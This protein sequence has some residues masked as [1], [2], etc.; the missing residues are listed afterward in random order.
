MKSG[1]ITWTLRNQLINPDIPNE[2]NLGVEIRFRISGSIANPKFLN[3]N[4]DFP[5]ERNPRYMFLDVLFAVRLRNPKRV[6]KTVLENSGLA[7]ARIIS[8]KKT[9]VHENSFANPFSHF[10]IER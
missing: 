6:W 5:I 2:R 10:T 1:L 9:P 3:L 4:P 8:K 7:R